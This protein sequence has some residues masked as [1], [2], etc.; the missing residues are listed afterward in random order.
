M[1][2]IE[3]Y[4]RFKELSL[5][6]EWLKL[7]FESLNLNF[8]EKGVNIPKELYDNN[9]VDERLLRK[10]EA[11]NILRVNLPRNLNHITSYDLYNASFWYNDFMNR[12]HWLIKE[13]R[14]DKNDKKFTHKKTKKIKE[15]KTLKNNSGTL[16]DV[17]SC[18]FGQVDK[19]INNA[20]NKSSHVKVRRGTYW[21]NLKN[22]W[23]SYNSSKKEINNDNNIKNNE[24]KKSDFVIDYD[25]LQFINMVANLNINFNKSLYS[26][27]YFKYKK[28]KNDGNYDKLSKDVI[29]DFEEM[30]KNIEDTLFIVSYIQKLDVKNVDEELYTYCVNEY[31]RLI[32]LDEDYI[33]EYI[34]ENVVNILNECFKVLNNKKLLDKKLIMSIDELILKMYNFRINGNE[35]CLSECEKILKLSDYIISNNGNIEQKN[36]LLNKKTKELIIVREDFNREYKVAKFSKMVIDNFK[37]GNDEEIQ[38]D[39]NKLVEIIKIYLSMSEGEK[40][41]IPNDILRIYEDALRFDSVFT[42]KTML[43]ELDIE[44]CVLENDYS[45]IYS[46]LNIYDRFNSKL[47]GGKSKGGNDAAKRRCEGR[48]GINSF[49][50]ENSKKL[51]SLLDFRKKMVEDNGVFN[52]SYF[53]ALV[54][55]KNRHFAYVEVMVDNNEIETFTVRLTD[56][57]PASEEVYNYISKK[58]SNIDINRINFKEQ[59]KSLKKVL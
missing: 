32:Q 21:A 31:K 33:K 55:R 37:F 36:T 40:S 35:E 58:Y 19:K 17:V 20:L 56:D 1:N 45:S 18:L 13:F 10:V 39:S 41:L 42:L 22:A 9:M 3:M 12:Y 47:R 15:E 16:K 49:S 46:C 34:S 52:I 11:Y 54:N 7:E 2:R 24:E 57:L 48:R 53:D 14:E 27:C 6:K 29:A 26:E 23:K 4:R 5:F 38:Y 25:I 51:D 59:E 43:E 50:D 30:T 8:T 28:I 44:K